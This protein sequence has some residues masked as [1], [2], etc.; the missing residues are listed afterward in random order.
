MAYL[1]LQERTK[2]AEE[3]VEMSFNRAKGRLRRL[4]PKNRMAYFRNAQS[5]TTLHTRFDLP[6]LGTRVT[7]VEG[8]GEG[9]SKRAGTFKSEYKLVQVEVEALA[10]NNT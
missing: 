3:L 10:D 6:T 5:P 9:D 4:D 8:M 1:N 7:L 2:L